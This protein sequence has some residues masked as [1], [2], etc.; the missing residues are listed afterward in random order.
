MYYGLA[1]GGIE[2]CGRFAVTLPPEAMAGLFGS[3]DIIEYQKSFNVAPTRQIPMCAIGKAKDRRIIK[4]RWGLVPPFLEKLDGPPLFNARSETII[5]K[6]SFKQAFAKRRCLI[7]SDGYYEWQNQDGKKT[8]FFIHRSDNEPCVFAGIWEMKRDENSPNGILLSCAIITTEAQ[9]E[10]KE[11]HH[12]QPVV[13]EKSEFANWLDES[14]TQKSLLQLLKPVSEKTLAF[15][16]VSNEVNSIRNDNE[17]LN[18]R[19][20]GASG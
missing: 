18:K 7:P 10:L 4:A 14:A 9:G 12:R 19:V 20:G 6:P 1:F 13:L 11:M 16:Q 3:K 5:E 15:Y 2:M 8:P 17:T